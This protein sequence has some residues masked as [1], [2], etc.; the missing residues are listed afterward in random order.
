MIFSAQKCDGAHYL[1]GLHCNPEKIL[2]KSAENAA[3]PL[4]DLLI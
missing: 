2:F 3:K 1:L 4:N